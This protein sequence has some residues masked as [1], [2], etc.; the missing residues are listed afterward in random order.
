VARHAIRTEPAPYCPECGARMVLRRP[1]PGQPWREF[2]GCNR[3]PD[4]PGRRQ[5]M[6]DGRPE[7]DDDMSGYEC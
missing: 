7:Q 4:C 3:W 2:W 1:R 5:I 6:E